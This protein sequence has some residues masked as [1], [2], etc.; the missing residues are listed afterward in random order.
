MPVESQIPESANEL[1][2][3]AATLLA[4]LST[5][6]RQNE[7][8]S[9]HIEAQAKQLEAL[10]AQLTSQTTQIKHQSSLIRHA[11][12]SVALRM[13]AVSRFHRRFQFRIALLGECAVKRM[14]I[15]LCLTCY[16]LNAA[17]RL[18]ETAQSQHQVGFVAIGS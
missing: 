17:K 12:Y 6:A 1:K 5:Q 13:A 11:L 14:R 16:R 10:A 3:F 4:Q 9:A 18:A 8:Q 15:Q 2:E 7:T